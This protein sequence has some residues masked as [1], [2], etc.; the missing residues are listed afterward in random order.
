[1]TGERR[2]ESFDG[3]AADYARYRAPYPDEVVGDVLHS[4][5]IRAGT[6]VLE[7]GCGTGQL[8]VPLARA[9]AE[10]VAVDL[11]ASLARIARASLCPYPSARVEVSAFEDWPLPDM[12]FDAV[13][14]ASAFHW[15]DP[16][17]RFAKS[18]RALRRGGALTIVHAHHV[19]GGTPGFL[20]DTQPYYLKWGLSDDPFFQPPVPADAH[21]MYPELDAQPGF[22]SVRRRRFEIPR[23]HTTESYVGWLRTDSLILSLDDQARAGFLNDIAALIDGKYDGSVARNFVYEV[24]T[25]R[26]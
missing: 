5:G 4:S 15:L 19:R 23:Q 6:R 3:A 11:G 7:I 14:S 10:L 17:V 16:H 9:G 12:P 8:S 21:V 22:R 2:R 24:I 18:A 1:V 13:V 25:A 26:T 20:E